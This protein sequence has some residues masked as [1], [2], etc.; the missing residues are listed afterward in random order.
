MQAEYIKMNLSSNKFGSFPHLT[1]ILQ[2]IKTKEVSF[3]G[4]CKSNVI[5]FLV[6]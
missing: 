4:H 3:T 2:V 5:E 6:N 1:F